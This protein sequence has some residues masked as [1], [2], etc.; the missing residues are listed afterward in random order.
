MAEGGVVSVFRRDMREMTASDKLTV[1]GAIIQESIRVS[2]EGGGAVP[3]CQ[4]GAHQKLGKV[5]KIRAAKDAGIAMVKRAVGA[6][7]ASDS[8]EGFFGLAPGEPLP[9][10]RIFGRIAG[11]F[12]QWVT[13]DNDFA[14]LFSVN[15][16]GRVKA[17]DI[18]VQKV[19][20]GEDT[21]RIWLIIPTVAFEWLRGNG[22][23]S[24]FGTT[25]VNWLQPNIQG[26]LRNLLP[27]EDA[28]KARQELQQ[29]IQAER[30]RDQEIRDLQARKAQE[31]SRS[32]QVLAEDQQQ[33]TAV[34]EPTADVQQLNTADTDAA[35]NIRFEESTGSLLEKVNR[36]INEAPPTPK[37]N[38]DTGD[39]SSEDLSKTYADLIGDES[40]SEGSSDTV[41]RA[42]DV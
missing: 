27:G 32:E 40:S 7:P 15:S 4:L 35:D 18:K 5:L 16:G 10:H 9:G 41:R 2:K 34:P 3:D 11:A 37:Y 22:W 6:I 38:E 31:E 26:G 29:R 25:S 1:E 17:E 21:I 39:L 14:H 24:K 8:C 12:R 13:E 42:P 36:I 20:Y 28:I 23:A 33:P 30:Q 19:E